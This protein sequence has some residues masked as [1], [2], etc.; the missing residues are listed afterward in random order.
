MQVI[1]LEPSANRQN[2][3][4]ITLYRFPKK[5]Y[6]IEMDI[7]T[8]CEPPYTTSIQMYSLSICGIIKQ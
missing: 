3:N 1:N 6:L 8:P 2:E 4:V 5:K 7:V